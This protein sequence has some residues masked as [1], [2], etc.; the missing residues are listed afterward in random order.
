[1]VQ[2]ASASIDHLQTMTDNT[3]EPALFELENSSSEIS[4]TKRGTE[5]FFA[6]KTCFNVNRAAS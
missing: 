4:L 1:M 5:F 6:F 2:A 3:L